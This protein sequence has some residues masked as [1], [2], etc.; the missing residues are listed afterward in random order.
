MPADPKWF[1]DRL[2]DIGMS[3]RKLAKLLDIEPSA[4][5]RTFHGLR[6]WDPQEAAAIARILGVT[7]DEVLRHAGVD[8]PRDRTALVPLHGVVNAVGEIVTRGASKLAGVPRPGPLPADTRALRIDLPGDPT[9]G[10]VCFYAPTARLDPEAIG[11]L[12]V[13]TVRDG[14][15]YLRIIQRGIDRGRWTLRLLRSPDNSPAMENIQIGAASPVLCI[16][17]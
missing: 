2:A 8:V 14:R 4:L 16:T 7:L 17:L 1:A 10:W 6:G 15:E 3:Q 5:S 12:A 11:R 13:V 9:D